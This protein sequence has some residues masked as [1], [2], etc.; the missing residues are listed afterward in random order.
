MIFTTSS[1]GSGGDNPASCVFRGEVFPVEKSMVSAADNNVANQLRSGETIDKI[2]LLGMT[3]LSRSA[4]RR[5][6]VN[7]KI[8][9]TISVILLSLAFVLQGVSADIFAAD[10]DTP[11][12]DQTISIDVE[13]VWQ[14]GNDADGKRPES[15]TVDL[16]SGSEVVRSI[17]IKA[18]SEGKWTGVFEDVPRFDDSGKEIQYTVEEQPVAGYEAAVSQGE[19]VSA[20]DYPDNISDEVIDDMTYESEKVQVDG[21]THWFI[22]PG[23]QTDYIQGTQ[24]VFNSSNFVPEKAKITEYDADGNLVPD[25]ERVFFKCNSSGTNMPDDSPRGTDIGFRPKGTLTNTLISTDHYFTLEFKD[26]VTILDGT[27]TGSKANVTIKVDNLSVNRTVNRNWQRVFF[28]GSSTLWAGPS[29]SSHMMGGLSMDMTFDIHGVN[30]GNVLLSFVDVDIT[31]NHGT[32]ASPRNESVSLIDGFEDTIYTVPLASNKYTQVGH[33]RFAEQADGRL[34]GWALSSDSNTLNSGFVCRADISDTGFKIRWTGSGCGTALFMQIKPFKLKATV[35]ESTVNSNGGEI[36]EQGEWRYRDYGRPQVI[37]VKPDEGY[38]VRYLKLDGNEVALDGFDEDGYMEITSGYKV[39]DASLNPG[40]INSGE[41]TVKLYQRENGVIDILLPPQYFANSSFTAP[42]RSDHWIDTGFESNGLA[43]NYVVVNKLLTTAEGT[44]TWVAG[45]AS[46]VDNEA[47]SLT[48]KQKLQGQDDSEAVEYPFDRSQISWDGGRYTISGLPAYDKDGNKY[49]YIVTETPPAGFDVTQNGNDIINTLKQQQI[50]IQ[51]KKT[52]NDGGKQHNNAEEITVTLKRAAWDPDNNRYGNPEVMDLT[53]VWSGDTYKFE[54]LPKFDERRY[55]YRYTTEETVSDAINTD[56]SKGDWYECKPDSTGRNFTNTLRGITSFSGTK[57]WLDGDKEHN[58]AQDIGL[59]LYRESSAVSKRS[60][61]LSGDMALNWDGNRYTYSNLPKYDDAG[62]PFTYSVRENKVMGKNSNEADYDIYYDGVLWDFNSYDTPQQAYNVTGTDITNALKG[63]IT[64]SKKWE[65]DNNRD[66]VRP[67]NVTVHLMKGNTEVGSATLSGAEWKHTFSG[68]PLYNDDG[69]AI[70][71]TV[72]EDPVTDESGKSIYTGETGSLVWNEDK[73]GYTVEITNTH[74]LET[75]DVTVSKIW[76]DDNDAD[77]IRPETVRLTL[78]ADGTPVADKEVTLPGQDGSWS[79]TFTGLPKYKS[80]EVAKEI[81]YTVQEPSVPA[82]YAES[83]SEDGLTVTN[84]HVRYTKTQISGSK[85]LNGRDMKAGEFEFELAG[86]DEATKAAIADGTVVLQS[87]SAEAPA[88]EDGSAGAFSFGNVTFKKAGTYKFDV[89]EKAPAVDGNGMTYD[90]EAKTVTVVVEADGNALK[91]TSQ[92]PEA[93]DIT[94]TNTYSASGSFT[95]EGRKTLTGQSDDGKEETDE[96]KKAPAAAEEKA[97]SKAPDAEAGNNEE[98]P[99]ADS[100]SGSDSSGQ[101]EESNSGSDSDLTGK[102]AGDTDE[103]ITPLENEEDVTTGGATADLNEKPQFVFLSSKGQETGM[104]MTKGQFAFEVRYANGNDLTT[105]VCSGENEAA[106]A[107]EEAP[108]TFGA[109]TYN[110]TL[111]KQ[112]LASG[113]A[114]RD[115]DGVYHISYVVTEKETGSA[116]QFNPQTFTFEVS[117]T[118]N[119]QGSLETASDASTGIAFENRYVTDTVTVPLDGLKHFTTEKGS[120]TLKE[121]D[122][123]FTAKA[124]DGAPAPEKSTAQND[125]GGAVHFGDIEFTKGDLGDS[126]EKTFV[127]EI[128]EEA[129]DLK[130]VTYDGSTETVSITVRDDGAGHLTAVTDPESAPMFEFE[131][132]YEPEPTEASVTDD[133][134]ISKVLKGGN[135]SAGQFS[136]SI[137]AADDF[138]AGN[139]K[140]PAQTVEKNAADG[141]VTFGKIRYDRVGTYSFT[142]REVIPQ[143]ADKDIVYDTSEYTVTVAV[144]DDEKGSLTVQS[145]EVSGGAKITFTNTL[146]PPDKEDP[147]KDKIPPDGKVPP[148]DKTKKGIKTGDETNAGLWIAILLAAA[149]GLGGAAVYR[150][151]KKD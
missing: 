68:I 29:D 77:G 15:I 118:D 107:G 128:T 116:F 98:E 23:L 113:A 115:A 35:D 14:D 18:D 10:D 112:L 11:P 19:I 41:E 147:P 139:A 137:E 12:V 16:K 61:N 1:A 102:E 106:E 121:G 30:E 7:R 142:V 44:K 90:R 49:E 82:G 40:V 132:T 100:A 57:T 110:T 24:V 103:S 87:G 129:G 97:D 111:L 92:T 66:G 145:Q 36:T 5:C 124:L 96:P 6:F 51:G 125:I 47:L 75:T 28:A 148:A 146:T 74:D 31:S 55:E 33:T 136:F 34:R 141:S 58:N 91:V 131:N 21:G 134:S 78:L 104:A 17:T 120:R 69:S 138:T 43:E 76:D 99:A 119:G 20:Y 25:G 143:N 117:V 64:V 93:K 150:R 140:L 46:H 130:G 38:H 101:D 60:L 50:T 63:S 95:P 62:N 144:A 85:T 84:T 108:I 86:S 127:Y 32:S 89:T 3:G 65:D 123:T 67:E 45:D 4:S 105:V 151:R 70:G 109:I 114:T 149:G 27:S 133:V 53:P 56:P 39:T 26:G 59:V 48:L 8:L 9:Y 88:A 122:F 71:Y 81:K 126:S 13:K 22:Q 135:L 2:P 72:T 79:H 54:N 80:G 94:F 73:T 83:Y 42:P 37:T 52:W